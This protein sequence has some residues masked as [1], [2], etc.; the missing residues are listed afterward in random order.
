MLWIQ[1]T[2]LFRNFSEI[3]IFKLKRQSTIVKYHISAMKSSNICELQANLRIRKWFKPLA[4]EFLP[5]PKSVFL[6]DAGQMPHEGGG[7]FHSKGT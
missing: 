5:N 2:L 1:T 4:V 6:A 7:F 3:V